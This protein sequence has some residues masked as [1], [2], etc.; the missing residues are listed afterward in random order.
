MRLIRTIDIADTDRL[1]DQLVRTNRRISQFF[2]VRVV[3][4]STPATLLLINPLLLLLLLLLL[5]VLK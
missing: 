3:N 4:L 5:L 2:A 1:T